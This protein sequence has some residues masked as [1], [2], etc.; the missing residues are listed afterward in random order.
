MWNR[1]GTPSV[2]IAAGPQTSNVRTVSACLLG[3]LLFGGI[4]PLLLATG[5]PV[6]SSFSRSYVDP[7]VP[8]VIPD[9][10]NGISTIDVTDTFT[11]TNTHVTI[12][13]IHSYRGALVIAIRHP[14]YPGVPEVILYTGSFA[15]L[16]ADV[17]LDL[18]VADFD[19][20]DSVGQWQVVVTDRVPDAKIG[21]IT[22][23]VIELSY[24]FSV[25]LT[26][27]VPANPAP[28]L[29]GTAAIRAVVAPAATVT[30]AVDGSSV[31][32]MVPTGSPNEFGYDL[33]TLGWA[34]GLHTLAVEGTTPFGNSLTDLHAV[35]F[36]NYD[37]DGAGVTEWIDPTSSTT[38][39][40]TYLLIMGVPSHATAVQ[41]GVDGAVVG[42]MAFSGSDAT[43]DYYI[44]SL[45]T[46][47]LND[48]VHTLSS[49]T[50][51]GD[52]STTDRS[53]LV[54]ID[55]WQV[56]AAFT[57]P[58]PLSSVS[59]TVVVTM[60]VNDA[61]S[62][63]VE[64]D[65]VPIG[66]DGTDRVGA[67]TH[68]ILWDSTAQTD[69]SHA[70]IARSIDFDGVEASASETV[71]VDNVPPLTAALVSPAPFSTIAGVAS[72]DVD[73]TASA[74]EARLVVDGVLASV[75]IGAPN[76]DADTYRLSLPTDSFVDGLHQVQ[77]QLRDITGA[78]ATDQEV[79]SF[80]NYAIAVVIT[81]PTSPP[82]VTGSFI[83]R[84]TASDV[85]IGR[86]I[87]DGTLVEEITRGIALSDT[88]LVFSSIDSTT[89]GDGSHALQVVGLGPG[90]EQAIDST[91]ITVDNYQISITP[92]LPT[93]GTVLAGTQDA[94]A[95]TPD[96]AASFEVR[97]GSTV[98]ASTTTS[99]FCFGG[100]CWWNVAYDSTGMTEGPTQLLLAASD[101]DG[102]W[103]SATV[104]VI[105]DN[106]DLT[107]TF[108]ALPATGGTMDISVQVTNAPA[109]PATNYAVSAELFVDGQLA[110][111]DGSFDQPTQRFTFT[112]DTTTIGD[113]SHVLRAEVTDTAGDVKVA[114]TSMPINNWDIQPSIFF[115][116]AGGALS[117]TINLWIEVDNNAP[118]GP[119]T[120]Y[121]ESADLLV[122][123]VVTSSTTTFQDLGFFRGFIF[124]LDTSAFTDG[125]H[126]LRA[127]VTD[128]DGTVRTVFRSQA[129]DN[130]LITVTLQVNDADNRI[131]GTFS[132][133]IASPS[134]ADRAE[135]Y[136]D[137]S[138]VSVQNTAV[139]APA[140]YQFSLD[141]KGFSDG[142][143]NLKVVVSHSISGESAT[144]S[145]GVVID[146]TP[147]LLSS[148]QTLYP[149]GKT[150]VKASGDKVTIV[151][152]ASDPTTGVA[153]VLLNATNIN[154]G[155]ALALFDDAS[156]QDGGSGD[157][158]YGSDPVDASGQMGFHRVFVTACDPVANCITK[159]TNVAIDNRDPLVTSAAVSYPV[160]QS[161]AKL[162]DSVRV[163]ASVVDTRIFVD[164]VMVIDTSGSMVGQPIADAKSAASS[165]VDKLDPNDRMALYSFDN[166]GGFAG[167][168]QPKLE[169]GWT[170]NKVGVKNLIN[171][172]QANDWTPLYST[173]K[174]ASDYAKTSNNM[175]VLVLLTDG[176]DCIG[177]VGPNC[178][179]SLPPPNQLMGDSI[180]IFSIGLGAGVLNGPARDF[181]DQ[182]ASSSNGGAFYPAPSS[183]DLDAIYDSIAS[184]VASLE[185]GGISSVTV[186]TSAFGGGANEPMYD[187]GLHGDGQAGDNVFGSNPVAVASGVTAN[188]DA[189]VTATDVGGNTDTL[190]AQARIDNTP[191]QLGAVAA[192]YPGTQH[193]VQDG[194]RVFFT[195]TITD[196]G[197]IGSISVVTADASSIGGDEAVTMLDDGV[198]NDVRPADANFASA[199]VLPATG[200]QTMLSTVRVTARD[201][202]GNT[203]SRTGNVFVDNKRPVLIELVDPVQGQ[204]I[205]GTY[206]FQATNNNPEAIFEIEFRVDGTYYT[207]AH[208]PLTGFHTLAFDTQQLL[209]GPYTVTSRGT[210]IIPGK[211]VLGN[212]DVDFFVDNTYPTL[213]LLA[214]SPGALL[215]GVVNVSVNASDL[216][217]ETVQYRVDGGSAADVSTPWQTANVTDGDHELTVEAI[218]QIGHVTS[219]SLA[220][221]VDN[222]NP[223]ARWVSPAEDAYVS[224]LVV[225][226]VEAQDLV[227]I[228]FVD[229]S[230]DLVLPLFQN[231]VSGLWEAG[232]STT[233]HPDGTYLLDLTVSDEAGHNFTA[234][235]LTISIDNI[236]PK[237][238]IL[239]PATTVLTG[240]VDLQV[241]T[242]DG[243]FP[244]LLEQWRLDSLNWVDLE[245]GRG[246]LN[247]TLYAEG[248]H[249]LTF[250]VEDHLGRSAEQVLTIVID[251][252]EPS[253]ELITP[254]NGTILGGVITVQAL[255]TDAVGIAHATVLIEGADPDQP[256]WNTSYAL[257]S[258][259]GAY[260]IQL[261]THAWGQ[262]DSRYRLSVRAE[263]TAGRIVG[264][265]PVDIIVDNED[266]QVE[267]SPLQGYV[268][269]ELDLNAVPFDVFLV[270]FQYRL[271]GGRWSDVDNETIHLD[272]LSLADGAHLLQV[273]VEDLAGHA[274]IVER[275]FIIDNSDPE[276]VI[277]SPATGRPV[278]GEITIQVY[279]QDPVGIAGL[280]L[281]EGLG[282][283]QTTTPL[284]RNPATGYF[285]LA[286]QTKDHADG[287]GTYLVRATDLAGHQANASLEVPV[288]NTAPTITLLQPKSSGKG[289]IGFE[290]RATDASGVAS[291]EVRIGGTEWQQLRDVDGESFA[292]A[293]RSTMEDNGEVPYDIRATDSIGNQRVEGHTLKVRN[294]VPIAWATF[295][296]LGLL[297]ALLVVLLVLTALVWRRWPARPADRAQWTEDDRPP[298]P[299]HDALVPP[300]HS[301]RVPPPSPR[302]RDPA[303]D[304]RGPRH[305]PAT[306]FRPSPPAPFVGPPMAASGRAVPTP[307]A[308][309]DPWEGGADASEAEMIEFSEDVTEDAEVF[310]EAD[311]VEVEEMEFFDSEEPAVTLPPAG[312]EPPAPRVTL[313][314]RE[315]TNR[316]AAP[317]GEK[318]SQAPDADPLGAMLNG[319]QRSPSP[320]PRQTDRP[321]AKEDSPLGDLIG[322]Y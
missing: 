115:P 250:R 295:A 234:P 183:S 149:F 18:D 280:V 54:I 230:G 171:A 2:P 48:D 177:F 75:T 254:S 17:S 175:P 93:A 225:L 49:I 144:A 69:G 302:G 275:S 97:V 68:T 99:V 247:T 246:S 222:G 262:G 80:D 5:A 310:E 122:D 31:G 241:V 270:T 215:G 114:T 89:L 178:V 162:G 26:D 312:T 111:V 258:I 236:G 150:A 30:L 160:G 259:S 103:A 252:G 172:L 106:Y 13:V 191:P 142:N 139:T 127:E 91:S 268:S 264:S 37:L 6:T 163:T 58:A 202:A 321:V 314:S 27:P 34:D 244:P 322:D 190:V 64:V 67:G 32:T 272:T 218:D 43:Y 88:D 284:F 251:N 289:T 40:G 14:G 232:V 219:V 257:A 146:N 72:F 36:T 186:D 210:E 168:N 214:P 304:P 28:T 134:V 296:S 273:R 205:E 29:S 208:N 84:A 124:T 10:G 253:V 231:P 57:A 116:A 169:T 47:L 82:A 181:L 311:P 83:V 155:S 143:H 287:S 300:E 228:S 90:S 95:T 176:A 305:P 56:S 243:P 201:W 224:G 138:L 197:A 180:P 104:A 255:V 207:T 294:E 278:Q 229:V 179:N 235:T 226:Q 136:I 281:V 45:D 199:D 78:L 192:T 59:G 164:V 245:D 132:G 276:L 318:V 188:R 233:S 285:E 9:F 71:F 66:T 195:S 184:Q 265:V 217:L 133:I 203:A 170:Q 119:T 274:T 77:V 4:L 306:S 11:L 60:A 135:L 317:R 316:P 249:Q 46:T 152:T 129:F 248:P 267:L 105:V 159:A 16:G 62:T 173:T 118:D 216:Y 87:L 193:W 301:Q 185:V 165:F 293:W 256:I 74:N 24:T 237:L 151:A 292:Y 107:V 320:S 53:V 79:Y 315:A 147:P 240:E 12:D 309:G 128:P 299:R 63:T 81:Q 112:L 1:H 271:D 286:L 167:G 269:G 313:R 130:W 220:L 290:V 157:D 212:N 120:G 223:S 279:A 61:D 200:L 98:L 108:D 297:I 153:S 263:D 23:S 42:P 227:G 21:T 121:A 117:G 141:T 100:T 209:D 55:N 94:W 41:W 123:G 211:T 156:H 22:T 44:A 51:G 174:A 239:S 187:D 20:L 39:S 86:L 15:D 7:T 125:L 196:P 154:G 3:L 19:G 52:G 291:V 148:L 158:Q 319:P 189:I 288:D 282:G 213:L 131:G 92:L 50:T 182:L 161:A 8:V 113:G 73:T 308:G 85:L 145:T 266:P 126:Q 198:G 194:Q 96:Y 238:T 35:R 303:Q 206:Q 33:D 260:G 137:G 38:M 298:R 277:V 204:Y 102:I 283:N 242:S 166:P 70:L 65:G 109:A 221:R 261:N 110:A 25:N 76:L 307:A 140:T 101:P